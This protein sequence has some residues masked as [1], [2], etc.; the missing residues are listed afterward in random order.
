VRVAL[1]VIA[2]G[3]RYYKFA[4]DLMD[5]AKKFFVPHD[6]VYFSDKPIQRDGLINVPYD[7]QGYP[8]ASY[9]RFHG[10]LTAKD[11]LLSYDQIFYI[12]ADM[13]FVDYV[14]DEIFSSGITATVHPGYVNRPGT[15]ET[16]PESTAYC[17]DA[18]SYYCGGFNG[19]D[20]KAYLKMS[21]EIVKN[22]NIDIANG[23]QA[24]WIDESH[25]NCWLHKNPPTK[26]LSQ[27]H[28]FP[29]N[30]ANSW[31]WSSDFVK[32]K[33]LALHKGER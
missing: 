27:A 6:I 21:E 9:M 17:P 28:C 26:V 8:A 13:R 20:S 4:Q 32:P 3:D 30:Y 2:T 1:L 19:G 15:P 24:I 11:M 22:I 16:R 7:Y 33:I 18:Q 23:V 12:D 10:F 31:G 25:M 14:S 29:E 5:S